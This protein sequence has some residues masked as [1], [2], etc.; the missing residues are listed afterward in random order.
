MS[1]ALF[2]SILA[3]ALL[4]VGLALINTAILVLAVPPLVYLGIGLLRADSLPAMQFQRELN[5]ET[6]SEGG[7]AEV[8]LTLTNKGTAVEYLHLQD[9]TASILPVIVGDT[10]TFAALDAGESL[11]LTYTVEGVRGSQH[12]PDVW[13]TGGETLDLFPWRIRLASDDHL[14]VVPSY[15]HVQRVNVRPLRT[16]G[17][18]GPI[19]SRQSGSGVDF[20]GVRPYQTGDPLR[21]VNWRL[22]A[23][24]GDVPFTT[25]FEQD[26]IADVGLIFDA[27]P[28]LS[29]TLAGQS[30]LAHGVEATAGIANTLLRDGHRVGLLLYGLGRWVFPGYGRVQRER[31]L[32]ELTHSDAATRQA[33]QRLSHLPTQLFPA[34]SQLIFVSP[35]QTEDETVLFRLRAN[36]YAVMI[37]SPD[38]VRFEAERL[39]ES[40]LRPTAVRL[41]RLERELLLQRLRQGGIIIVDWDTGQSLDEA[42]TAALRYLPPVRHVREIK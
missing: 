3:F 16:M 9:P 25:E 6:I 10:E 40:P 2:L 33:F 42:V 22:T 26:R 20:F 32:R 8:M 11:R 4:L 29:L 15:P 18:T 27:R 23:R 12:L 38:P 24:H 7:Q 35:L 5:V 36:G 41:A 30:L 21:R 13:V 39:P 37:V 34:R 19:P 28:E 1:R 17:F 31:I 14:L